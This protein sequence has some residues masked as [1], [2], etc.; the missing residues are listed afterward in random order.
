VAS[1]E[2]AAGAGRVSADGRLAVTAALPDDLAPSTQ[3][4]V[5]SGW[6]ADGRPRWAYAVTTA[7]PP[8]SQWQIALMAVAV[9]L[10]A[11]AVSIWWL[12]RR[13]R[14]RTQPEEAQ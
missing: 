5:V 6:T 2:Q 10:I 4:L 9:L 13:R 7:Q 14:Q 3:T 11:A 8:L 1:G 12:W